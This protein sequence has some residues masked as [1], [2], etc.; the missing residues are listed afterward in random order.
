MPHQE[1]RSF[2]DELI[3][4][5]TKP[6]H[7]GNIALSNQLTLMK[8]LSIF[9]I[10]LFAV[11]S[12]ISEEFLL[13]IILAS[14]VPVILL[15]WHL[16]LK[17]IISTK[18]L[19]ILMS[20]MTWL[21]Y[22]Y[23]LQ[24]GGIHHTGMI[25]SLVPPVIFALLTGTSSVFWNLSYILF[26]TLFFA[27]NHYVW[28]QS[29]YNIDE[30]IHLV[31]A[32]IFVSGIVYLLESHRLSQQL[33]NEL[34][35]VN[36]HSILNHSSD[37]VGIIDPLSRILYANPAYY[38]ITGFDESEVIGIMGLDYLHPDDR[39][40][41]TKALSKVVKGTP[42]ELR[43]RYKVKE[44][45]W[46]W[47]ESKGTMIRNGK[48][49]WMVL[50]ISRDV[51]KQI[52]LEDALQHSR[53]MEAVGTLAGGI[54]HNVN[55]M[56]TAITN[57]TFLAKRAVA[58]EDPVQNRLDQID[59]L[60]MQ[61]SEMID[62]LL[63]FARKRRMIKRPTNLAEVTQNTLSLIRESV[64]SNIA[65]NWT[66]PN[67]EI[68]VDGDSTQLQQ[69]LINL[70][71]NARDA[72]KDSASP[73][74]NCELRV[75]MPDASFADSHHLEHNTEMA[76]IR[77]CDN[78]HGIAPAVQDHIFEPFYTTKKVGQGFG[79]GLSMVHGT[80]ETH[81]GIITLESEM[82]QGTCFNIY[83]PISAS[84]KTAIPQQ[85]SMSPED[86]KSRQHTLMLVDDSADVRESTRDILIALGYQTLLAADGDEAIAL[87]QEN[88]SCCDLI[89]MD[90]MMPKT[91]GIEAAKVIH[92]LAPEKPILFFSAYSRDDPEQPQDL[93]EDSILIRKPIAAQDLA[94]IIAKSLPNLSH[95]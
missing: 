52:E 55:N 32:Y 45:G 26:N 6:K 80:I 64:P 70:L 8:R 73:S 68:W 87:M 58:D 34:S 67:E 69:V 19:M 60:A 42:Q 18:L 83:I 84:K 57:H 90:V 76:Y 12:F 65:V 79:L 28:G 25:W 1:Q 43:Y 11:V 13:A 82:N 21:I 77:I 31:G 78:G 85:K 89:L 40:M 22:T 53:K 49:E 2:V 39:L 10:L 93:P 41:A 29:I 16:T 17:D 37:I 48:G 44:G 23:L 38:R 72:C 74:I 86:L 20:A 15:S 91:N 3:S 33:G 75:W 5:E 95:H 62:Q 56:L 46:V 92:A 4:Q 36:V 81:S 66:I 88:A 14:A 51:T 94:N 47:L 9:I 63:S 27:I 54:A 7:S 30:Y 61:T 59:M 71:L 35:Q 50:L 24:S